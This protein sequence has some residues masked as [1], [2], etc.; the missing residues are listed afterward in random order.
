MDYGASL[1]STIG[2]YASSAASS[3]AEY[4]GSMS[5]MD[6]LSVGSTALN[7]AGTASG[8]TAEA[9]RA[10]SQADALEE[11]AGAIEAQTELERRANNRRTRQILSRN[12]NVAAASG[13]DPFS[14]SPLELELSNRF[15]ADLTNT[16]L[17][18]GGRA[19]SRNN[20]LQARG[21]RQS[22]PGLVAGNIG[23]GAGSILGDWYRRTKN[24]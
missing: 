22:I 8:A 18:V 21:L 9:Q 15:E 7:L 24:P 5:A 10:S 4:V 14:G 19:A 20:M 1:F 11:Q 13:V 17:G 2:Q 16:L 6:W 23:K 12:R 3:I